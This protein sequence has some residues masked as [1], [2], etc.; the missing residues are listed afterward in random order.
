M[1]GEVAMPALGEDKVRERVNA[2]KDWRMLAT[3]YKREVGDSLVI[4]YIETRYNRTF[5]DPD[6]NRRTA[7]PVFVEHFKASRVARE[8]ISVANQL[9]N[10]ANTVLSD[11]MRGVDKK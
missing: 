9:L 10:T 11:N 1:V 4:F 5:T 6:G 2:H 7:K 8:P 3:D